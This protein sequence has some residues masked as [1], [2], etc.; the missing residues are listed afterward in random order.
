VRVVILHHAPEEDAA[1]DDHDV[2]VQRDAVA[3]ALAVLGHEPHGLGC[4]LDLEAVRRELT[5][6]RPDLAF[7]LVES[8]GRTDRLMPLATLLL[9][10]LG[11]RYTGSR[12]EAMLATSDKLAAKRRMRAAG[13]PTP[14]FVD[15]AADRKDVEGDGRGAWIVKPVWEH[16]S[17]GMDEKAVVTVDHVS[18]LRRHVAA[19]AERTGRPHFA[20]RFV[21]GREFN[22]SLLAGEVLP[23]AEI[24][25]S[26][27]PPGKPRIVDQ[28]AKWEPESFEYRQ[29][30][31]RFDFPTADGPLLDRL[32]ADAERCW[33]LFNLGGYARV[34]FRVDADGRPWI[35]E[36]NVNPC[37]SPDAGFAAALARAG[38]GYDEAIGRVIADAL[39]PP[40]RQG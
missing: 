36:V 4:T 11:I 33:R 5:A 27:F 13:L 3:A 1:L 21:D 8:L 20:E 32:R 6:L 40:G 24:D 10:A 19:R 26:S 18:E 35:L 22:L 39:R 25:F 9:D 7:N 17:F 16:A 31:R 30:P 12:T 14:D 37:L 2:M 23:P 15:P 34:D 38:I 28:R 29:T